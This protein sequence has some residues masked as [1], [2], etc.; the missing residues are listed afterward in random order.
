MKVLEKNSEQL[1]IVLNAEKI[2][3]ICREKFRTDVKKLKWKS[4]WILKN[5]KIL[6]EGIEKK[7]LGWLKQ[8]QIACSRV[9]SSVSKKFW[10]AAKF[11]K[12]WSK[13]SELWKKR[14]GKVENLHIRKKS[15]CPKK[16]SVS[17][18]EI[19]CAEKNYKCL[20]KNVMCRKIPEKIESIEKVQKKIQNL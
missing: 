6:K 8:N 4:R 13:F 10:T 14:S 3:E 17:S 18:H 7:N 19:P 20:K 11:P 12:E 5:W 2:L 9:I 1:E 15:S 16:I